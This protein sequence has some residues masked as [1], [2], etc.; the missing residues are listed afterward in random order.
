VYLALLFVVFATVRLIAEAVSW[1]RYERAEADGAAKIS[2]RANS[3]FSN[4]SNISVNTF[5]GVAD[6]SNGSLCVARPPTH[7]S[8]RLRLVSVG[9]LSESD[10]VPELRRRSVLGSSVPTARQKRYAA[11]EGS[12]DAAP[13]DGNQAASEVLKCD[14]A[15]DGTTPNDLDVAPSSN[16]NNNKNTNNK[17][18]S[19]M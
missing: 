7:Q 2:T 8:Q 14:G 9:G 13:L 6:T 18:S 17:K 16:H 5:H 15:D 10:L 4:I 19:A 1:R 3:Y 12:G 11:A